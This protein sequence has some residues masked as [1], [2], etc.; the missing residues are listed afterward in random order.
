VAAFVVVRLL[1]GNGV[2]GRD[3]RQRVCQRGCDEEEE[4]DLVEP[5]NEKDDFGCKLLL[6]ATQ[7][8]R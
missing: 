7:Q 8:K 1:Y 4:G 3:R 5:R 2:Q 6:L